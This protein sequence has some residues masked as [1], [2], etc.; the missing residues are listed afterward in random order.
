MPF[1][2]IVNKAALDL[3]ALSTERSGDYERVLGKKTFYSHLALAISL[4]SGGF[5]AGC[6]LDWAILFSVIPLILSAV[7]AAL[8]TEAPTGSGTSPGLSWVETNSP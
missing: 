3:P 6:S 5:I 8:L 7:F 1:W 4:V 2:A